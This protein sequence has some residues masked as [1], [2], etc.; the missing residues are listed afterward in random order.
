ME[1]D[2]AHDDSESGVV[3]VAFKR[4]GAE[5]PNENEGGFVVAT[6]KVI[7]KV[8]KSLNKIFLLK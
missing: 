8:F 3:V 4:P 1:I 5:V 2:V 7:Q 6:F